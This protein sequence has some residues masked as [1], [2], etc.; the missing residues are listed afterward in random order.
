MDIDPWR[1]LKTR[2]LAFLVFFLFRKN[3][4]SFLNFKTEG[5]TITFQRTLKTSTRDRSL[6]APPS[7]HCWAQCPWVPWESVFWKE[8]T[9][10]IFQTQKEEGHVKARLGGK[11]ALKAAPPRPKPSVSILPWKLG[12]WGAVSPGYGTLLQEALPVVGPLCRAESTVLQGQ[13]FPAFLKWNSVPLRFYFR[14][15]SSALKIKHSHPHPPHPRPAT[16]H[17]KD[18]PASFWASLSSPG[19][20]NEVSAGL[21]QQMVLC[22]T[23]VP[24]RGKVGYHLPLFKASRLVFFFFFFYKASVLYFFFFYQ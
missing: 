9:I 20:R 1:S 23:P 11:A 6:R 18:H 16:P 15:F 22:C 7:V 2:S 12:T 5:S 24:P 21:G 17:T 8:G 13:S 19:L 3:L 4:A 10:H 14:S